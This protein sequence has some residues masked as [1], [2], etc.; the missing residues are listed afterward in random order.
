MKPTCLIQLD[1]RHLAIAVGSLKEESHIEIH[2]IHTKVVTAVLK[3]H[4]DMIDS[5]LLYNFP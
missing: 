5:L 3:H 2:D 1:R 4:T